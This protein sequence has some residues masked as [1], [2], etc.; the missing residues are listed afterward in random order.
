MN[1][2]FS[3]EILKII[4][5][6]HSLANSWFDIFSFL[7]PLPEAN[8]FCIGKASDSGSKADLLSKN[9]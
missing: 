9:V 8:V 4:D 7:M 2:L 5:L 3:F 6:C 1:V